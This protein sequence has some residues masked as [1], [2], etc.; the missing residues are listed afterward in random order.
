[1]TESVEEKPRGFMKAFWLFLI[2]ALLFPVKSVTIALL[3]IPFLTPV[4]LA[5]F[6][7]SKI[8]AVEAASVANQACHTPGVKVGQKIFG[9]TVQLLS[10]L[11]L[12]DE[13]LVPFFFKAIRAV[14]HVVVLNAF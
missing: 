5:L 7:L 12:F 11:M 2:V 9:W 13:L 8:L 6:A 14:S 3:W 10:V 4:F 1:M